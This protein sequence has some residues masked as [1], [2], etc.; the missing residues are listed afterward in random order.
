[1]DVATDVSE[2]LGCCEVDDAGAGEAEADSG[3]GAG[4]ADGDGLAEYLGD[5]PAGAPADGFVG[6]ELGA[7]RVTAAMV[8]RLATA[9]AATRTRTDSQ[10]P[11]SLA[12]LAALAMEPVTSLA[13]L[14]AVSMVVSGSRVAISLC[15]AGMSAALAAVT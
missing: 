3:C 11:R 2:Q 6:A 15:T 7:R 9:K 8:S 1:V 4:D 12:S 13:R 10:V 14:L 5:D